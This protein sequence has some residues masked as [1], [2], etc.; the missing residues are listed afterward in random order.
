MNGFRILAKRGESS[1]ALF[2]AC[3]EESISE[4]EDRQFEKGLNSKLK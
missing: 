1:F 3:I 4:R 2:L